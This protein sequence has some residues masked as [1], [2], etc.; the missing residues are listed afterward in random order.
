MLEQNGTSTTFSTGT[1]VH[2]RPSLPAQ[3]RV[4]NLL[5]RHGDASTTFYTGTMAHSMQRSRNADQSTTM[6][7]S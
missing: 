1:A 6:V 7:R 2:Q 3:R 5:C 4:D